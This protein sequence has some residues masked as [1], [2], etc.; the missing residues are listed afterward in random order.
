MSIKNYKRFL[1]LLALSLLFYAGSASL[2]YGF[3]VSPPWVKTGRLLPGS[4]Y[5]QKIT[6]SRY[7]PTTDLRATID[8][9]KL[10]EELQGWIS[11]KEGD[12]FMLPKGESQV[13]IHFLV[14]VPDSAALKNYKGTIS[15]RT[16]PTR[17]G[18]GVGVALAAGIHI[19]LTVS[20]Q[21]VEDMLVRH[22]N[23]QKVVEQ[24]PIPF[25][26]KIENR[27]NVPTRPDRVEMEIY[28]Q[29]HKQVITSGTATEMETIPAFET[30]T[31]IARVPVKLE[32][33][34]YWAEFKIIKN[35][36][37]LRQGK[38]VFNVVEREPT[39]LEKIWMFLW[40]KK[41]YSI[42]GFVL[43]LTVVFLIVMAKKGKL[44]IKIELG[45]S[46][47]DGPAVAKKKEVTEKTTEGP[48]RI[49]LE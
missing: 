5:E 7:Q 9:S 30:K 42:P 6:I 28:D 46:K 33:G 14:E 38:I 13:P 3:G 43:V 41:R 45:S 29:Y 11:V 18:A 48:T 35:E 26:M 2:C 44:H 22:V 31:I 20:D 49:K 27:G 25:H 8:Y 24:K 10:S 16:H 47:P 19:D 39:L 21:V 4:I 34:T 37:V 1:V 40:E 12:E 23:I 17:E 36:N 32:L 15:I